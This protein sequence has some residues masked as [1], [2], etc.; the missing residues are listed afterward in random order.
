M[1]D[2][3]GTLQTL[4]S[5][6]NT[7]Q[8]RFEKLDTAKEDLQELTLNLKVLKELLEKKEA[9]HIPDEYIVRISTVLDGV[10]KTCEKCAKYLEITDKKRFLNIVQFGWSLYQSPVLL[11][12]INRRSAHLQHLMTTLTFA[13]TTGVKAQLDDISS[14]N[15]DVVDWN[16]QISS[17]S[18][19]ETMV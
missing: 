8:D 12:E 9:Q 11:N 4:L 19:S 10:K 1:V 6:V 5:V 2:V 7:V 18:S 16:T 3:L 15:V 14:R 13:T 17:K